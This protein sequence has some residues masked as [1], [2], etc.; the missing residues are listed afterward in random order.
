MMHNYETHSC[1][2]CGA[3]AM[4]M[5]CLIGGE[6]TQLC[7]NCYK[8]FALDMQESDYDH[9]LASEYDGVSRDTNDELYPEERENLAMR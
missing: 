1:E 8:Q 3:E 9:E 2:W 4:L 6:W 7:N 5:S